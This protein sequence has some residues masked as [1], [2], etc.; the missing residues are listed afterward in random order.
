MRARVDSGSIDNH[1]HDRLQALNYLTSANI[2]CFTRHVIH[3]QAEPQTEQIN[4]SDFPVNAVAELSTTNP[5]P[6][7]MPNVFYNNATQISSVNLVAD[8]RAQPWTMHP[9]LLLA[10]EPTLDI[11]QAAPSGGVDILPLSN[12]YGMKE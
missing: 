10:P 1:D 9:E 2:P 4:E 12:Y 7:D 11:W 3:A 8:F 6:P 5:T